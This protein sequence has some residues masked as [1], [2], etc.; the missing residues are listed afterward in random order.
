VPGG[1]P[2]H[3]KANRDFTVFTEPL[4]IQ[5]NFTEFNG[6]YLIQ[7]I[8]NGHYL[9]ANRIDRMWPNSP[10][11]HPNKADIT[12]DIQDKGRYIAYLYLFFGINLFSI[13][14]TF[15]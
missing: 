5:F 10:E 3:F 7:C 2:F 11:S 12:W 13:Y 1:G 6:G 4:T 9:D 8:D 14:F 15:I